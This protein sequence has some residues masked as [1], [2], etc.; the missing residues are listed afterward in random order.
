LSKLFVGAGLFVLVLLISHYRAERM[1]AC[2]CVAEGEFSKSLSIHR[3]RS[4][5]G[6]IRTS[7]TA[8]RMPGRSATSPAL[9]GLE[10]P[11]G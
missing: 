7:C 8:T 10:P 3:L 1:L 4:A 9:M 6:A 11:L 2:D 5:V